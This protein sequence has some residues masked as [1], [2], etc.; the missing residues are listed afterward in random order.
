MYKK[1]KKRS[2]LQK[3]IESEMGKLLKTSYN[4]LRESSDFNDFNPMFGRE[5]R[6]RK[7]KG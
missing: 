6:G 7:G 2:K 1:K 5:E 3:L 4:I